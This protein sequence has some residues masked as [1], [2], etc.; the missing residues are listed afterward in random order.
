MNL[1][2]TR[3]ITRFVF[4]ALVEGNIWFIKDFPATMVKHYSKLIILIVRVEYIESHTQSRQSWDRWC[5]LERSNH[6]KMA[7]N[8]IIKILVEQATVPC[9]IMEVNMA[10]NLTAGCHWMSPTVGLCISKNHH[11][12][13]PIWEV[14]HVWRS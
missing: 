6:L 10:E 1:W 12:N 9:Q 7:W 8:I 4:V 11:D 2:R 5:L 3:A 14:I 13:L